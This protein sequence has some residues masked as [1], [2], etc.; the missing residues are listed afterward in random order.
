MKYFRGNTI[1]CSQL[2]QA[3]KRKL[4]PWNI[5]AFLVLFWSIVMYSEDHQL[6]FE[7]IHTYLPYACHYKPHF[8]Y[9]K[10]PKTFF[11]EFVSSNYEHLVFNSR[12]WWGAYGIRYFVQMV[13]IW[14]SIRYV[15]VY[16]SKTW[17]NE[18]S[19]PIVLLTKGI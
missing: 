3:N 19:H 1:L 5:S 12:L 13:V 6:Y 11:K 8:V 16:K 2:A 14:I 9:F 4:G 17:M 15:S 18:G 10:Q 7:R